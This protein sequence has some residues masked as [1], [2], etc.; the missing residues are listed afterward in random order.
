MQIAQ[1][2]RFIEIAKFNSIHAAADQLFLST[3]SISKFIRVL[4]TELDTSLF[5]RSPKGIELT[6]DGE[7]FLKFALQ[8]VNAY[9]AM[10]A[11]LQ[12]TFKTPQSCEDLH[13]KLTIFH[14]PLFSDFLLPTAVRNF[15]SQYSNVRLSVSSYDSSQIASH[16]RQPL[17]EKTELLG[18]FALPIIQGSP[19]REFLKLNSSITLFPLKNC[20]YV[21]C[22]SSQSP[23]ARNKSISTHQL[24]QKERIISF[25]SSDT[26]KAPIDR[27]IRQYGEPTYALSTAS[28]SI[29]F[30]AINSGAGIGLLN[31]S[32]LENNSYFRDHRNNFVIL[33]LNQP[34]NLLCCAGFHKDH[35][36]IIDHFLQF[37]PSTG[38]CL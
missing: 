38:E 14:T 2:E 23:Y 8:T 12:H 31:E 36:H 22:V 11:E 3:Q 29:F 1:M 25:V 16:L 10:R 9:H 13:G 27:C 17:V 26:E 6:Q 19:D 4:E 35:H 5:H 20:H 34:L 37:L 7:R 30:E 21:A 32:T 33:R 15:F 24:L 18:L 28:P